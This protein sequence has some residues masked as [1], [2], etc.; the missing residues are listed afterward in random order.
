MQHGFLQQHTSKEPGLLQF[1]RQSLHSYARLNLPFLSS[2][3]ECITLAAEE[4]LERVIQLDLEFDKMCL[5]HVGRRASIAQGVALL[6]LYERALAPP[7]E[8][9][10]GEGK[11]GVEQ[12]LVEKL[13]N[14]VRKGRMGGHLP[15]GF[16]ALT[17]G[18]GL[19]LGLFLSFSLSPALLTLRASTPRTNATP[20]PLP[21]R[22]FPPLLG[23]PVE[24]PR[25]LPRA[26]NVIA[27]GETFGPG[28]LGE[29]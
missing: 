27:R 11:K 19:S 15:V 12:V 1:L 24:P 16:A 6:T 5:N 8:E 9:G 21:T 4:G 20:L 2:V 26:S 25:A 28:G 17:A 14:E 18:C 13:R 22:A 7:P 29:L 23:D 3:H 10:E